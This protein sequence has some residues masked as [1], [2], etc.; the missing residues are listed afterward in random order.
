LTIGVGL[1]AAIMPIVGQNLGRGSPQIAKRFT[2]FLIGAAIICMTATDMLVYLFTGQIIGSFI[3]DIEVVNWT[4]VCMLLSIL[5]QPTLAASLVLGSALRGAGDTRWPAYSTI[6]GMWLV[7]IP[8]TYLLIDHLGMSIAAAWLITAA[9]FIVRSIILVLRF[10][11]SDWR[12]A[13]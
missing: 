4:K 9:D 12:K 11:L 13:F 5:E 1:A 10:S 3:T 2:R 6:I 7:R 8:L